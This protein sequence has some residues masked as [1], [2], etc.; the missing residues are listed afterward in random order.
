MGVNATLNA[1][2]LGLAASQFA[3]DVTSSNVTNVNTPGYVRQRPEF[4]AAGG[5]DVAA[6]SFQVGVEIPQVKRIYDRY[7]EL[8]IVDS[9]TEVGYSTTAQDYLQRIE[10][11]FNETNGGGVNELLGKFWSSWQNLSMN[12][13]GQAERTVVLAAGED[14]ASRFREF[15]NDLSAIMMDARDE[16]SG[17][18]T[19]INSDIE[20]IADLNGEIMAQ[21]R[22]NGDANLLLDERSKLLTSLAERIGI[23]YIEDATGNVNIYLTDGNSL[24]YGGSARQLEMVGDDIRIE[25]TSELI[26]AGITKGKLGAL[27]EV[28]DRLVPGYLDS[29]N[30]LT[31]GIIDA[32]NDQHIK[33]Y[34]ADGEVAGN[35]FVPIGTVNTASNAVITA[36]TLIKDIDSYRD[37]AADD[38]IILEG[39][40][41]NNGDTVSD[42][43][44]RISA[45]TTVGDLLSKIES[46]FGDVGDV[47][48]S[49]TGDGKIM[50]VD[51]TAGTSSLA[52]KISVKNSG[53]TTDNTIGFHAD[54]NQGTVMLTITEGSIGAARN[55]AVS[56]DIVADLGKIAA[57][58]TVDGNGDNA[59]EIGSISDLQIDWG[60][61]TTTANGFYGALSAQV[62]QD[63]SNAISSK[64]HR[65]IIMNQLEEKWESASGVSVDEEMMNL[66]KYQMSYNAAGRLVTVA[67]ELMDTLI[68]LGK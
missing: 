25:G 68:N 7:V 65:D 55:M 19:T 59:L 21:G 54:K 46:L 35:F 64:D 61:T 58:A 32:V 50:V 34:T 29:L 40:K 43:T 33:G 15:S 60:T 18:I 20:K 37:W 42:G 45:A 9:K 6:K 11:L 1:A 41:A 4:E 16:I 51:N 31:A 67:N 2:R 62:G 44:F 47:T 26:T 39:T 56:A 8:Q 13:Q 17:M 30:T 12:P 23:N 22:D 53:G 38:Y 49:V 36:G 48:A 24:V 3:I 57:S 5:I 52:I 14:L 63:V 27:L 10:G 66:I 28:R